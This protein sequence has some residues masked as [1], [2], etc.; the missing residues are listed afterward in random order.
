VIKKEELKD[1]GFKVFIGLPCYGGMISESVFHSMMQLQTWGHYL[2]K[3][4]DEKPKEK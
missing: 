3:K 4:E 2:Q 1:K